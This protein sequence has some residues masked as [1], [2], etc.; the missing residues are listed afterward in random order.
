MI[1][2]VG[3]EITLGCSPLKCCLQEMKTVLLSFLMLYVLLMQDEY[4]L[5]HCLLLSN[6]TCCIFDFVSSF[7][8]TFPSCFQQLCLQ[9]RSLIPSFFFA[10]LMLIF[11]S[12]TFFIHIFISHRNQPF[13]PFFFSTFSSI[14]I[15]LFYKS[16]LPS[17]LSFSPSPKLHEYLII[18]HPRVL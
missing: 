10:F 1:K 3:L 2:V 12:F 14:L 5:G 17:L 4:S 18:N 8:T 9:S 7:S 11:C 16:S 15:F 13:F 6:K